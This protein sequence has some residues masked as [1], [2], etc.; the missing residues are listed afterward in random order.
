MVERPVSAS[1]GIAR[2][3]RAGL[4][5][6][7][8]TTGCIRSICPWASCSTRKT[9]RPCPIQPCIRTPS[10]D[11]Y[12]VAAQRQ[13]RRP[14]HLRRPRA[15]GEAQPHPAD[16]RLCLHAG[17][18]C[19]GAA[20]FGGQR[21]PRRRT[22]ALQRRYRGRRLRR[23]VLGAA[24]AAL[25]QRQAPAWSGQW[26]GPGRTQL[27]APQ[28]V[29]PD[30]HAARTERHRVPENPRGQRLVFRQRR[31]RQRLGISTRPDADVREIARRA[32]RSKRCRHGWSGCRRC[33]SRRWRATRSTSGSPAKICRARKTASA[34]TATR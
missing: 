4:H 15:E 18:R 6:A 19:L 10:F 22:R 28:P 2:A 33:R 20:P 21:H 1:P 7:C 30:G 12:P 5:E 31:R 27:H 24:A 16:R 13:G 29:D 17:D 3:A 9:A 14:G 25:G 8:A 23:A 26:L 32:D 11:G 34:T